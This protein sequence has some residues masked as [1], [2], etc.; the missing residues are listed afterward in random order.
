MNG[1]FASFGAGAG[2]GAEFD[3]SGIFLGDE[4]FGAF[5]DAFLEFTPDGGEAYGG[6]TD[7]QQDVRGEGGEE[8]L[9][10]EQ[11]LSLPLRKKEGLKTS[12]SPRRNALL[13]APWR[14]Q[15]PPVRIPRCL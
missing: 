8:D 6:F 10:F 11:A 9:F 3:D 2:A 13:P 7:G 4:E 1:D 5:A 14:L 15:R 12:C